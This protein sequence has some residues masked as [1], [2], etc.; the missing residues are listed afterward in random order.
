MQLVPSEEVTLVASWKRFLLQVPCSEHEV[1]WSMSCLAFRHTFDEDTYTVISDNI[2][3][4]ILLY[5]HCTPL[6]HFLR[7]LEKYII[8]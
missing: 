5:N 4:R 2:L 8:I 7:F 6:S 1:I 3:G